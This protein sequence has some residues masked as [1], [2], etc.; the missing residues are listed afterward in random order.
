[1]SKITLAIAKE[2]QAFS[3][4]EQERLGDTFLDYL[5]RLRTIRVELAKG[6]ADLAEGRTRTLADLDAAIAALRR[7]YAGN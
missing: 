2:L 1:M 6:E 7:E 3:P 5:R 4:D